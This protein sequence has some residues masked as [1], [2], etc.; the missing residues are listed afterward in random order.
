MISLIFVTVLLTPDCCNR[1][2]LSWV[3]KVISSFVSLIFNFVA[4]VAEELT[5]SSDK[6]KVR[7]ISQLTNGVSRVL[8]KLLKF[9]N[10]S[11]IS[12]SF[13]LQ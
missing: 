10:S 4:P 3:D 9:F 2:S 11:A 8:Q 1:F 13:V 6:V 5:Q 12:T 7:L